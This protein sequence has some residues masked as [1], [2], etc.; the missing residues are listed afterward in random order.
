MFKFKKLKDSVRLNFLVTKFIILPMFVAALVLIVV[1]FVHYLGGKDLLDIDFGPLGTFI[2]GVAT[3]M[4]VVFGGSYWIKRKTE[5]AMELLR[6]FNLHTNNMLEI[7]QQPTIYQYEGYYP[8]AYPETYNN[9]ARAHCERP[10][11]LI[12]NEFGVLKKEIALYSSFLRGENLEQL[13]AL[14]NE[15]ETIVLEINSWLLIK[16]EAQAEK[17]LVLQSYDKFTEHKNDL[18]NISIKFKTFLAP[19]I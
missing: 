10:C 13:M 7:M 4:A 14:E 6:V 19:F 3:F 15:I 1:A 8:F 11:R 5:G 2:T 18:I 16:L 17:E 9:D 12:Y